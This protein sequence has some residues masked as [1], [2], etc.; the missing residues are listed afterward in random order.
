MHVIDRMLAP[1]S[2]Q[3]VRLLCRRVVKLLLPSP[4]PGTQCRRQEVDVDCSSAVLV[5]TVLQSQ[6]LIGKACSKINTSS[7]AEQRHKR[8]MHFPVTFARYGYFRTSA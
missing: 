4:D 6:A 5:T 3:V 7:A 8:L 1:R 2:E